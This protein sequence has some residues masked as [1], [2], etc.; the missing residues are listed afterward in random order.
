[1]SKK[2]YCAILIGTAT[3]S[4]LVG[5]NLWAMEE[6]QEN[7]ITVFSS[8]YDALPSDK[9]YLALTKIQNTRS[10]A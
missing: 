7:S 3:L 5:K 10:I 1:M 2:H 9:D 6:G 8:I 4:G